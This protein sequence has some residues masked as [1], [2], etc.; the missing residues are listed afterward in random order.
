MGERILREEGYEVVSVTDGA[1]ALI[2]WKDFD[3]DLVIADVSLPSKSGYDVC[4]GIKGSP[5]SKYTKVILTAGLLEPF[6]HDQARE[7][8]SDGV[9]RKPFEASSM[10]ETVQTLIE[11]SEFARKMFPRGTA[12]TPEPAPAVA[13][14]VAEAPPEAETTNV[15]E[16][17][18]PKPI[19]EE[20]RIVAE[21]PATIDSGLVRA[22]VALAVEAVLPKIIDEIT[23]NVLETLNENAHA[24]Q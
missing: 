3:P 16:L 4:K 12:A 11:A 18:L 20:P 23:E 24:R 21:A 22:A 7:A 13:V 15:I 5:G 1:T 2:R 9:L 17:P 14:V 10:I 19:A 8:G 6:D